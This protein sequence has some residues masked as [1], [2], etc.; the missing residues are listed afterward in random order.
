MDALEVLVPQLLEDIQE[1]LFNRALKFREENT[2]SVSSLEEFKKIFENSGGFVR[3][4][5]GG[6]AEEE[7]AIK[8]IGGVTVRCFPLD[9]QSTG[10][11][12]FTGRE[13]AR[14]AIFAKSY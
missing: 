8:E 3:T 1:N 7:K 9:D 2:F 4:Y 5:F 10:K 12:F 14:L 13:G 11:C 6:G